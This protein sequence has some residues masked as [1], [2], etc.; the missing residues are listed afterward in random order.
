[1]NRDTIKQVIIE[2]KEIL[3]REPYVKRELTFEPGMNYCFVG[4]RRAGKSFVLYQMIHAFIENG[5]QKNQFTYINFEDERLMEMK[6]SDLNTVVEIAHEFSGPDFK[7]L[8]FLDEMQNIDGWDKFSRR[9]ADMKYRICITGSNSKMLSSEM[10][11][12]LGGRF[13]IR[14]VYPFSFRE[15]LDAKGIETAK[16][17]HT[18]EWKAAVISYFNEFL[19]FGGFPELQRIIDKRSYLSNL[20]KTVFLGD[21]ITRNAVSNPFAL[22]LMIKKMAESVMA[23]LSFSRLSNIIAS[24]GVSVGKST[25]IN[26]MDYAKDSFLIFSISNY[27]SKLSEKE[28]VPKYYF[29]DQGLESLFLSDASSRQFENTVAIELVRRYGKDNV[30]FYQDSNAEVDFLIPEVGLAIQVCKTLNKD[31]GTLK[32][33]TNALAQ[34][35]SFLPAIDCF[36]LTANEEDYLTVKDTDIR[37]F[38][39]WK[40]LLD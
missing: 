31:D 36:I 9:L 19:S 33:E 34:L 1:M 8:L 22:R 35:K 21:I 24:S 15:F 6:T 38:P 37:I 23:P 11:S 26:Y 14:D 12:T 28:T 7:P 25:V 30:F 5:G 27:A 39:L 29:M 20:F 4:I 2:Q 32:R 10:A 13:M 17:T 16:Q 18:T 3:L 40:W